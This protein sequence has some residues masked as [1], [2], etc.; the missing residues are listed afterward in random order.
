ME[1]CSSAPRA[2]CLEQ[3]ESGRK[4]SLA[5]WLPNSLLLEIKGAFIQAHA[6]IS[7][8][9][10]PRTPA[11]RQSSADASFSLRIAMIYE[12]RATTPRQNKLS[13]RSAH[14]EQEQTPAP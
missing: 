7:S 10:H 12:A 8:A 4:R 9:R 14:P 11:R 5:H 2:I 1:K 3:K 13:P 6:S